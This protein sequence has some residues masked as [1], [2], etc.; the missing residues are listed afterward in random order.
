MKTFLTMSVALAV[1]AVLTGPAVTPRSGSV[2]VE[3]GLQ[4]ADPR[5]ASEP[6]CRRGQPLRAHP[7]R[8]E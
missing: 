3:E 2:A 5:D 1:L 4:Q 6:P 8:L 7:G